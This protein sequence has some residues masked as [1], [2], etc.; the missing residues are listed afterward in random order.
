MIPDDNM[1]CNGWGSLLTGFITDLVVF[2]V[3]LSWRP[4]TALHRL[5][6]LAGR[7]F[8]T[9]M[10]LHDGDSLFHATHGMANRILHTL[11]SYLPH[12]ISSWSCMYSVHTYSIEYRHECLKPEHRIPTPTSRS[13]CASEAF[14]LDRGL[15]GISRSLGHERRCLPAIFSRTGLRLGKRRMTCVEEDERD[16]IP[17]RV[18]LSHPSSSS[19][20]GFLPHILRLE[21]SHNNPNA[22][23]FSCASP[24]R[25]F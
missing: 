10:C 19:S 21:H 7:L 25:V 8:C 13:R 2:V 1:E 11:H 17:K 9:C 20:S 12:A 3:G 15:L 16:W 22:T 6:M 14:S 23:L 18:F 24:S 5:G 4:S